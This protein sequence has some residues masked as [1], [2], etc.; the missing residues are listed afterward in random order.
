MPFARHVVE[1]RGEC[2]TLQ[3]LNSLSRVTSLSPTWAVLRRGEFIGTLPYRQ[4]ESSGEL[5]VRCI[6]WLRDL[7]EK[8]RPRE[9]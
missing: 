2:Y 5:E 9:R 1:W 3:P 7:L 8:P 4:T 6:N